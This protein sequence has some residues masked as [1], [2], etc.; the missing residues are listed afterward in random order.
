MENKHTSSKKYFNIRF[1]YK[2]IF[3]LVIILITILIFI[4]RVQPIILFIIPVIIYPF[5]HILLQLLDK[6][7]KKF[8]KILLIKLISVNALHKTLLFHIDM[9][10]K[11]FIRSIILNTSFHELK[12]IENSNLIYLIQ[13]LL[14]N[15]QFSKKICPKGRNLLLLAKN[16]D[17]PDTILGDI[18]N[19]YAEKL[20]DI[21]EKALSSNNLNEKEIERLA[22]EISTDQR[23]YLEVHLTGTNPIIQEIQKHSKIKIEG[24][25][26]II[27]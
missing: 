15:Q 11:V 8:E 18:K 25:F 22:Y 12:N 14:E 4:G 20:E 9:N 23:K 10:S 24:D 27:K 2:N 7:L 3:H 6:P 26:S 1:L 13:I 21:I 19:F 17:F 5:I 16:L